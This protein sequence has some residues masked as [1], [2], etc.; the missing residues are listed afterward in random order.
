MAVHKIILYYGFAPVTDPDAV[1]LWQN[2]LCESLNLKGRILISKHG[3]NGTLG[4]TLGDLKRY[5]KATKQYPG[6]KKID[7]K[8]S[9]GTG[10]DFPRLSVKARK[11]LVAFGV[12][13]DLKVDE[14]GVIGGGKHLKPKEVNKLAAELGDD[15]V[16]FD[17]RN[18]YEAKIG[19]FKNA[20]VPDV[21]TTKDFIAELDSGKYDH[22]KNKTIITYCTGGIRCEILTT[23]MKQRGFNEVYQIEG[24]I[25]RYGEK[26][27]DQGLWEGSLYTFDGRKT[28]DFSDQ[29]PV[30]GEC[31]ACQSPTKSFYNCANDFCHNQYLLCVTCVR[32]SKNLECAHED[33][34]QPSRTN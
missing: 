24:G 20:V 8:W 10:N 2:T 26:Y 34:K 15:L 33:A 29:T 5:I 13:E 25:V 30:I 23:V 17:G 32:D 27:G 4:G 19:K 18:A 12:P 28:I 11:E 21:R 22:L 31:D 6:F 7:F 14:K 16:F 3:I 9:E 1:R